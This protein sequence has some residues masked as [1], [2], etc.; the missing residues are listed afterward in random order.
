[1]TPKPDPVLPRRLDGGCCFHAGPMS[2]RLHEQRPRRVVEIGTHQGGS[3]LQIANWLRE[4]D[5][6][7][8]CVDP[9]VP[10]TFP[11]VSDAY[12]QFCS[13]VWS[14]G[15]QDIVTPWR[16]RS[17]DA[18]RWVGAVDFVYVDGDH[19]T[20]GVAADLAA[21]WPHLE[22]GGVICGD[23]YQAESVHAAWNEFAASVGVSL[24]D[25]GLVWVRK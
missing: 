11:G 7:L 4:W 13:N 16:V 8:L 14:D 1:M 23:D 24:V 15:L 5:G 20:E 19:T 2:V 22:P 9:W 6:A 18:A 12:E 21:W 10:D 25:E 17:E 3:A